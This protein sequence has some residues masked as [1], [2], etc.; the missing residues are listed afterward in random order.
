[1]ARRSFIWD[2]KGM[3][4]ISSRKRVPPLSQFELSRLV[5]RS[6]CKR[7]FF[8]T[9]QLTLKERFGMAPQSTGIRGPPDLKL[10]P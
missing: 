4:L 8:I 1:M 3:L 7:A 10:A 9:E 6:A 5:R 2:A